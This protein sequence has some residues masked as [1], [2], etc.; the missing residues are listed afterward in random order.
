MTRAE[1]IA[2][3]RAEN[4]EITTRVA[5]DTVL[6][7]WLLLGDK[8]VCAITRC[9]VSDVVFNSVV[10][11][12][13]YDTRYDLEAEIDKF[14][15]IDEF[16]GGGVSFDDKSLTKTTVA[17]L[18]KE[19]PTWRTGSAGTP[20]KWYRRGGN[21]YFDRPVSTAD[22]E[23][24]VYTVLVSDDFDDDDIMPFNQLGY[25]EPFHSS[26]VKYL[27]WKAKE[28]VGKPGEGAKARQEFLDYCQWMKKMIGGNKYGPIRLVPTI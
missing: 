8:E 15:D 23:I 9:I 4:R 12:S 6:E 22:L 3:F 25:L 2:Q 13:V 17:E 1:I 16:P 24:R 10:S 26:L 28:K 21:L 20:K 27:Q 7:N 19:S 5:T 14:Y 11:T 18:D